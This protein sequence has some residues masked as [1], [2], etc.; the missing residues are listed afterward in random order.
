MFI[1]SQIIIAVASV[2]LAISA[3]F[4]KRLNILIMQIIAISLLAVHYGLLYAYTGLVLAAIEVVRLIVFAFLDRHQNQKLNIW[5]AILF[6]CL[7]VSLS[8]VFWDG[9]FAIFPLIGQ[10]VVCVG[11]AQKSVFVL[12]FFF[13]ISAAC[14]IAYLFILGSY[15]GASLQCLIFVSSVVGLVL[16][17]KKHLP[18]D[19]NSYVTGQFG[20]IEYKNKEYKK[21]R[22]RGI[23]W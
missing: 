20:L 18:K 21:N 7:S 2:L 16:Y 19:E 23:K 5:L 13:L 4:H 11:L 10:C 22:E 12:K 8:I 9:W 1:A 3:Q 15:I 17:A 6:M 14:Y